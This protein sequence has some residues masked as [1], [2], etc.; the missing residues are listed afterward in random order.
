MRI[1]DIELIGYK[2]LMYDQVG[3]FR[4]TLSQKIQLILGTNG[5]GKSSLMAE[6]F[7]L[8]ADGNHFHKGGSKTIHITHR[9]D[10]YVLKNEYHTKAGTHS[11]VK[12]GEELNKEGL[13]TSQLELC[14]S[15]FRI[16][17][18]VRELLMG[19]RKFTEM[20]AIERREWLTLLADADFDYALNVYNQLREKLRDADRDVRRD[21]GRL[22]IETS[23]IITPEEQARLKKEVET[24][25]HELSDL[26]AI[27]RPIDQSVMALEAR[28][29]QGMQTLAEMSTR[30]L[31]MRLHAP[32]TAY[33]SEE[34]RRNDWNELEKPQFKSIEQIDSY[35]GNIK[36]RIA[37]EEAL[38]NQ[39][40]KDHHKLQQNLTVLKKTGQEGLTTLATN[41]Q[42]LVGQRMD[43]LSS[44]KLKID[45]TDPQVAMI[46]FD[47]CQ[48][49][50][51]QVFSEIP[52]NED[53][54]FSQAT[55]QTLQTDL[56]KQREVAF[57]YKSRLDKLEAQAAHMEKHLADG[58]VDCPKCGHRF[59]PGFTDEGLKAVR[60]QLSK[61]TALHAQ[62]SETIAKLEGKLA[63]FDAYGTLYRQYT[64]CVSGYPALKPLW[65]YLTEKDLPV[66]APRMILP[67]LA[68]FRQD[69]LILTHDVALTKQIDD[70]KEL[71]KQ[72]SLVGDVSLAETQLHLE[73]ISLQV[74]GMTAY[75]ARLRL[76]YSEHAQYRKELVEAFELGK[77]IEKLQSDL[78]Q[79]TSEMVDTMWMETVHHCIRQLQS[80]LNR[81]E[82][83][84]NE[85]KQQL[86]RVEDLKVSIER[87]LLDK[88]ALEILV[89][90]LSPKD[91]LIAEGLMGFIKTYTRQINQI[92][93]KV[94]TYPLVVKECSMGGD[95]RVELDYKFPLIVMN[96]TPPVPDVEDGS[97]GQREIIDLA[98]KIVAM[99]YLGL[100]HSSLILDEFGAS[101]DKAHQVN[102][103][104]MI[105]TL[106][107]TTQFSQ[108]FMISHYHSAYGAFANVETCVLDGKNIVV[109][110]VYNQHVVMQ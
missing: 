92:L 34:P 71:M 66:T 44:L 91:G 58:K 60:E 74:E 64:G 80:Q 22:T 104:E 25:H 94:W 108:L 9:G 106:I 45:V 75:L 81:K 1:D 4:M 41:M 29:T 57:G 50:L 62:V 70:I 8:P 77:K 85:V 73:E 27:R 83:T 105:K 35:L 5:S 93:K 55:R 13:V 12:N 40:V 63:E 48:D 17:R 99:R 26:I 30:L 65:D 37:A 82:E 76:K 19:K 110:D 90:T 109:P 32:L 21:Q 86:G 16:N 47:S 2:R 67:V 10:I 11:F 3:T 88:R 6:L 87:S 7:P 43:N 31:R 68:H 54:R 52:E 53:K 28:Q 101:F 51:F 33:G 89:D 42:I 95:G 84:L 72:K 69:L 107:D 23:K 100:S 49:L 78:T 97:L 39:A 15:E 102:A 79:V 56:G 96:V 103:V 18:K 24:I 20:R 59:V 38:I 61:G 46:A 98:F 14:W 36:E